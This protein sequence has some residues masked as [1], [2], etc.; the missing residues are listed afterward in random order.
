[1]SA[2]RVAW[3]AGGEA[4]VLRLE[5]DAIAVRSSRPWPPG[6]RPEGVVLDAGTAEGAGTGSTTL[7]L[8]MKVHSCKKQP[9]GDFVV[10]GRPLDLSREARERLRGE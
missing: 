6:S 5:A 10:E 8:R 1:M 7:A 3:A 2:V 9:E 4:V